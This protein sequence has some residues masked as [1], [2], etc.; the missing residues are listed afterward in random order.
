MTRR[1]SANQNK[2]LN[3]TENELG[4][5]IGIYINYSSA[6]ETKNR[7]NNSEITVFLLLKQLAR[8]LRIN[9]SFNPITNSD[10]WVPEYFKIRLRVS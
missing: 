9:I 4:A 5:F 2:W 7:G 10:R 1:S 6:E 8:F 3:K